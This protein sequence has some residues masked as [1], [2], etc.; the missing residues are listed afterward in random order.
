MGQS[1]RI[2]RNLLLD[3]MTN[4]RLMVLAATLLLIAASMVV[5]RMSRF[6]HPVFYGLSVPHNDPSTIA[7][8]TEQTGYR[9]QVLNVFV[10]LD[11]PGF[12]PGTL[13]QISEMGATPMITLE[14]WSWRSSRGQAEHAS[15]SL[16]ALASGRWDR[17]VTNIARTILGYQGLVYLRFA[18]EMNGWWYPWAESVNSNRSG[19]Y[20]RAWRH[21]HDI[22]RN[23]GCTNVRW[24]WSPN[25]LTASSQGTSDLGTLYPGDEYVDVLGMTAYGHGPSAAQTF[26]TTLQA[27]QGVTHN[28]NIIISE[29]GADGPHKTEWITSFGQYL[30][31]HPEIHGFVWFNTTPSTTGASGDYRFDDT[32]NNLNAFRRVLRNANVTTRANA[33]KQPAHWAGPIARTVLLARPLD[34]LEGV[35]GRASAGVLRARVVY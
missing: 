19:D 29:T 34:G 14:P 3:R 12:G 26:D 23:V 13:S 18:H 30:D 17:S 2:S 24:I 10:K 7:A 8:L 9:P 20:V 15:Y 32:P 21:V 16:A 11:S 4:R 27:L 1:E 5:I 22:F 33:P 28:K 25:A 35:M 6:Q 31:S